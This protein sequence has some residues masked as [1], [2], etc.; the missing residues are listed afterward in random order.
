MEA[1]GISLLHHSW[2]NKD[3]VPSRP[4]SSTSKPSSDACGRVLIYTGPLSQLC[5]LLSKHGADLLPRITGKE[6]MVDLY[7]EEAEVFKEKNYHHKE[8]VL[9]TA[10]LKQ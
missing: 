9:T 7:Q 4:Y 10:V 2:M 6:E 1:R 5:S 3:K 8:R